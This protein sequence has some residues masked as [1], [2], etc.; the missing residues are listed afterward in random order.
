MMNMPWRIAVAFPVWLMDLPRGGRSRRESLRIGRSMTS[1][2]PRAFS[3]I[4]PRKFSKGPG[5]VVPGRVQP[6]PVEALVDGDVQHI[7]LGADAEIDVARV[8]DRLARAL[9]RLTCL[10]ERH[11]LAGR[12][13]DEDAGSAGPSG[14]GGDPGLGG[15][16]RAV[17]PR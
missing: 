14:G 8:P 10:D 2:S 3:S 9:L 17:T 13:D 12:V 4:L 6:D 11:L 1:D 16:G 7:L 15:D 5:Y